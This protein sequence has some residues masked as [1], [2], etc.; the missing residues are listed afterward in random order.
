MTSKGLFSGILLP[1]LLLAMGSS[2]HVLAFSQA[3]YQIEAPGSPALSAQQPTSD[4]TGTWSG[5]FF[6]KHS[7][8]P[9]FTMTITINTDSRGQIVGSSSSNSDCLKGAHLEVT[10]TGS[11]VVL[12]GSSDAGENITLRGTVDGTGTLLKADYI[13]NGGATGSCETDKGTGS[14]VKR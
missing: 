5:T 10:V 12:A 4:I 13:L 11:K 9:P 3:N 1:W 14:L 6:S 8:V 2:V 7:N